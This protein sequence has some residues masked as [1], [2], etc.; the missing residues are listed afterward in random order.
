MVGL[1]APGRLA[2]LVPFGV[3]EGLEDQDGGYLIHEGLMFLA[4][5]SG[6]IENGVRFLGG[7]PLVPQGQG[8]AGELSKFLGKMAGL[9]CLGAGLTGEMQRISGDDPYAAEPTAETGQG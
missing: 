7:Q 9:V 3:E 5:F 1:R 8:Q 4:S 2:L 6:G